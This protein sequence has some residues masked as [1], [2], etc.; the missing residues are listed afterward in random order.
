MEER[1]QNAGSH[2]RPLDSTSVRPTDGRGRVE[3]WLFT[4]NQSP[5]TLPTICAGF[6]LESGVVR[7]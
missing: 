2:G 4:V 6:P 3:I 7:S 1:A 5:D